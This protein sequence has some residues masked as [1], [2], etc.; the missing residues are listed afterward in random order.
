MTLQPREKFSQDTVRSLLVGEMAEALQDAEFGVRECRH[1]PLDHGRGNPAVLR[2]SQHQGGHGEPGKQG[3]DALRIPLRQQTKH[4][5]DVCRIAGQTAIDRCRLGGNARA[6]GFE[7][8]LRDEGPAEEGG[9]FGH[10]IGAK[11]WGDE[12]LQEGWDRSRRTGQ[13]RRQEGAPLGLHAPLRVW[14]RRQGLDK[15]DGHR[16]ACRMGDDPRRLDCDGVQE[17]S[18]R[19]G[20][21]DRSRPLRRKGRREGVTRE[22]RCHDTI[23][24]REARQDAGPGMGRPGRTVQQQKIRSVT[25]DLDVETHVPGGDESGQ[26]TIGPVGP[27]GLPTE[28]FGFE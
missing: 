14:A 28:S 8:R 24:L 19:G 21:L 18:D 22:V 20:Q 1:G 27:V 26:M 7:K 9:Q 17:V 13:G 6:G 15:T 4:G 12:P 5:T 2:P 3:L 25:G 16:G 11:E 10:S 23:R